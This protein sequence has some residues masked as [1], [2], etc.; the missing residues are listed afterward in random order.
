MSDGGLARDAHDWVERVTGGSIVRAERH[1]AGASRQAYS[2]DVE[3]GDDLVPLFLL[4]DN[5]G[6]GGGS[7]R[8]GAV[9]QAL[10]GT[11]VP[12]PYVHAVAPE[13]GA[14]L[15]ERV[16]GR[17][18]FPA[19]DDEREREPTARHLMALTAALHALDPASLAIAHLGAPGDP[20]GHAAEQLAKAE[21]AARLVGDR[22]APL[23]SFALA[24]LRRNVPT[25]VARSSLVH[26]DMGPGNFLA[27][28]GRVTAVLDWEVA[29][30]GD[31]MEDL[32]AIA[33]R[34]MATPVGHLPTRFAEYAA[35]GGG[36]V[37]LR[38][39]EWYRVLVLARNAMMIGLGLQHDSAALDRVQLTMF[40]TLLMRAC[41]LSL[42]DAVG[43]PRPDEA[44][45]VA[46][47]P[48]DDTRLAAHALRDLRDTVL[49][50]VPRS[51]AG[52]RGAGAAAVLEYLAHTQ[53]VGPDYR[54]RELADLA[55]VIGRSPTDEHD[56]FGALR[57]LVDDPAR[58]AELA[59][60]FGRH[61]LRRGML[62]APLF[63]PLADR[64]PQHLDATP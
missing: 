40:R 59:A 47:P 24:W 39:V 6:S 42:C 43:V 36:P 27:S 28:A 64:H 54:T 29:H 48:T 3:R 51:F 50:A 46:A 22:L 18:D 7:A 56:G 55:T 14:L 21:G 31:P 35:A 45:L 5:L 62:L 34:D 20:G 10:A 44:P 32:A 15:L 49:P 30:W 17:S 52:A 58:E 13:L 1:L 4:R 19:V 41:A 53:Q 60:F 16:A 63:G 57:P 37:D 9:L 12:V 8:D 11:A 61:L 38:R 33:V 25:D 23:F 26:S 2:I